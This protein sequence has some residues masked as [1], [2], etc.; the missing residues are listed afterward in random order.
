MMKRLV[1]VTFFTVLFLSCSEKEPD[2]HRNIVETVSVIV[3]QLQIDQ[4]DDI[5]IIPIRGCSGCVEKTIAFMRENVADNNT[6]YVVTA[7]NRTEY[8]SYIDEDIF[9]HSN[10]VFDS[11][12][13]FQ[14]NDLV[15]NYP[16][17]Y[18][19]TGNYFDNK[20]ELTG[21]NVDKELTIIYSNIYKK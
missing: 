3:P 11:N 10:V 12:L 4:I 19:K 2:L 9:R 17:Y 7:K 14:T 13:I 16:M 20:V 6:L 8:I 15:N 1:L 5:I 21:S 18:S